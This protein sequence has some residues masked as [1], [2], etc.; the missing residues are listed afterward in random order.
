[1]LL[2]LLDTF[3]SVSPMSTGMAGMVAMAGRVGLHGSHGYAVVSDINGSF[4][5]M[6]IICNIFHILSVNL[7]VEYR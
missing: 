7:H 6:Y 3:H 5:I 2:L 4:F 1:M